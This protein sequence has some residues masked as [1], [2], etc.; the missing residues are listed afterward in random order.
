[1]RGIDVE[2]TWDAAQERFLRSQEG[3]PHDDV[4]H[5]RIGAANVLLFGTYYRPSAIDAR[6]PE[7]Q[8]ITEGAP[9]WV[10]SAGRVRTGQWI[11]TD[12]LEPFR[13]VD[14]DGAPILLTPGNTWIELTAAIPTA[15]L[16]EVTVPAEIWPAA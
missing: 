5:G 12:P 9:L 8:T 11:R 15:D 14:D 10:F 1:M 16:S 4:L 2:W 7:A 13:L 3:R 6:S